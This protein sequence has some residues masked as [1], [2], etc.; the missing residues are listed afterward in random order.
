LFRFNI[1]TGCFGVSIEPKQSKKN[2]NKQKKGKKLIKKYN[3]FATKQ[4]NV[5]KNLNEG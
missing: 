3:T 5:N 2:R 1:E 4:T